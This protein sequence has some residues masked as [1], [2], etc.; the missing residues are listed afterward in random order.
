MELLIEQEAFQELIDDLDNMPHTIDKLRN[1]SLKSQQPCTVK[2]AELQMTWKIQERND[3]SLT[4]LE[5]SN[6]ER[7]D[8]F[9]ESMEEY[10]GGM[11]KSMPLRKI[12]LTIWMYPP[13][14]NLDDHLPPPPPPQAEFFKEVHRSP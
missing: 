1:K 8:C 9:D 3:L 2:N 13:D 5:R 12:A 11:Y 14:V 4:I 7:K 10:I 6:R